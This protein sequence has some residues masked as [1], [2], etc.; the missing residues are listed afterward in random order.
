MM[1]TIDYQRALFARLEAENAHNRSIV[2]ALSYQLK[3]VF[4]KL[5][6]MQNSHEMRQRVARL[7]DRLL[8][9][10]GMTREQARAQAKKRFWEK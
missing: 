6:D 8:D 2:S 4:R 5:C 10:I 9:D 7:D 3:A 1:K